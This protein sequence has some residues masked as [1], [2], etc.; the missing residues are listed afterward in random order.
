MAS[1]Y[2]DKIKKQDLYEFV[3]ILNE[4][5]ILL[6][7]QNKEFIDVVENT[8]KYIKGDK[9]KRKELRVMQELENRWY[10][11]L[12]KNMPD[13][14]VYD[15][16]NYIADTWVCWKNYS[17]EYIK[18]IIS[19]KSMASKSSTGYYNLKSIKDHM[20]NV[21]KIVDLGC[22]IGYTTLTFKDIF[23]C[24]VIGT[25]IKDTIQYKICD[26]LSQNNRFNLVDT[27]DNLGKVDMVFASEYFEHFERPV[28]HLIDVIQKL[29][30]K[31]ILFANTFNNKSIGHFDTYKHFDK[32]YKGLEISRM[33]SKELKTRGYQKVNTNCY[34]NR[35]NFY[36]YAK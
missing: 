36:E 14:S 8:I 20:G 11:S 10:D 32:D 21:N 35:P 5:N 18:S 9:E 30:P 17:R 24:E 19:D 29:K 25:N 13:Y 34:N 7:L 16:V 22:G 6:P 26:K 33:F 31:Y 3:N 15:D 28:E 1:K 4:L 2:L 12:S 27:I 23:G